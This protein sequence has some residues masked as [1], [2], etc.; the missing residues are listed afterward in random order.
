MATDDRVRRE[1]LRLKQ[2]KRDIQQGKI[3]PDQLLAIPPPPR[4]FIT[5]M[6]KCNHKAFEKYMDQFPLVNQVHY[7]KT[8]EGMRVL[9]IHYFWDDQDNDKLAV[10]T[11]FVDFLLTIGYTYDGELEHTPISYQVYGKKKPKEK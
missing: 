2:Q 1:S 8:N 5:G 3:K 11:E 7:G 9:L 10:V 6:A 4:E